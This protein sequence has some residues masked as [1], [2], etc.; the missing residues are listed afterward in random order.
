MC[1]VLR[2]PVIITFESSGSEIS[3]KLDE[4]CS[5]LLALAHAQN[6]TAAVCW[7]T[8]VFCRCAG[9][10]GVLLDMVPSY[11]PQSTQARSPY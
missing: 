9:W 11:S 2:P 3:R 8:A 4:A 10:E 1:W 6:M 7:T 5:L